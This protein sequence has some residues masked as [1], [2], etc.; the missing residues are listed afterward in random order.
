MYNMITY[1]VSDILNNKRKYF[2]K[3]THPIETSVE[4]L[5]ISLLALSHYLRVPLSVDQMILDNNKKI[6]QMLL[7][8][9]ASPPLKIVVTHKL[10]SNDDV[11]NEYEVPHHIDFTL[12]TTTDLLDGKSV[13]VLSTKKLSDEVMSN[14]SSLAL[15]PFA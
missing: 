11:S 1:L 5:A 9:N 7:D 6:N 12:T 10:A 14:T 2:N 4:L 8:E 15:S 3:M 13:T